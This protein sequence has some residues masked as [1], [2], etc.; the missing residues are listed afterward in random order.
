MNMKYKNLTIALSLIMILGIVSPTSLVVAQE[1]I[2]DEE[3]QT[4]EVIEE[5]EAEQERETS[6]PE[7]PRTLQDRAREQREALIQNVRPMEMVKE[8]EADTSVQDFRPA[9]AMRERAQE[10]QEVVAE[11]ISEAQKNRVAEAVERTSRRIEAAF[12]RVETLA[13]RLQARL[14]I[15]A[16]QG[17]DIGRQN[18]LLSQAED[19][20]DEGRM[21]LRQAKENFK[22]NIDSD[23]PLTAF[24]QFQLD[25]QPSINLV[26][27]AHQK[28]VE[29]ISITRMGLDQN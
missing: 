19:D 10:T 22:D 23:R 6:R 7:P 17:L 8:R 21:I 2:E 29:A 20:I 3:E 5:R 24:R 27:Q 11:R 26:K 25:I 14:E 16:E 13:G 15:L 4:N 28:V 18:D 1:E 9:E 12:V